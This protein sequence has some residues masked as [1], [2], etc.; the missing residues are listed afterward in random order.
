MAP[1]ME[2]MEF[3]FFPKSVTDFFYAALQKIKSNRVHSEQKVRLPVR[4]HPHLFASAH[5]E[6][7]SVLL[8]C[9]HS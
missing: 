3:S 6:V 9:V 4:V 1:I 8:I 5:S 7:Q 2:K